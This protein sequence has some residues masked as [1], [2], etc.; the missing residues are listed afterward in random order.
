MGQ[1]R[2]D[3]APRLGTALLYPRAGAPS[4]SFLAQRWL[5][6]P[7]AASPKGAGLREPGRGS[8]NSDNSEARR[9]LHRILQ[10]APTRS[11]LSAAPPPRRNRGQRLVCPLGGSSSRSRW[12]KASV[13]AVP[14]RA[15]R[16]TAPAAGATAR[17][18]AQS[19]PRCAPS[20]WLP[21][22][23]TQAAPRGGARSLATEPL[24]KPMVKVL[25]SK[26]T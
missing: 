25:L 24:K 18:T 26:C 17:G 5:A 9:E 14:S 16:G 10:L 6:T 2:E 21:G 23:S 1:Q 12:P 19:A 7:L 11:P 15:E 8:T 13:C 20:S 3:N 22:T 4:L